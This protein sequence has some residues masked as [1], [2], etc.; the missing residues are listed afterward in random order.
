MIY[1]VIILLI[2]VICLI[3]RNYKRIAMIDYTEMID[4]LVA[5]NCQLKIQLQEILYKEEN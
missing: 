3:N 2:I 4:D 1:V 5:E